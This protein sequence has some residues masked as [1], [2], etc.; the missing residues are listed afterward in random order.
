MK[1]IILPLFAFL[2]T[3]Q[4]H[5]QATKVYLENTFVKFQHDFDESL[6]LAKA[7]NKKVLMIF[8][9][10]DWCKPC[11]QLRNNI[12]NKK[13]FAQFS[14]S[15]LILLELDFP[16]RKKNKLPADQKAHNEALAEQYNSEG[17]FPKL[18][19]FDD[20]RKVIGELEYNTSMTSEQL[21]AKIDRLLA[22]R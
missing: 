8:S 14:E 2:L 13:E 3:V 20:N 4:L 18:I 6:H 10:S 1:R 7:S 5:A 15:L 21:M 17:A 9:G 16:Y 11:I 12:L 19:L 22:K